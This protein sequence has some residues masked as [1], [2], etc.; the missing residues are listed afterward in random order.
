[1]V[2]FDKS[3]KVAAA[4]AAV[5]ITTSHEGGRPDGAKPEGSPTVQRD[6]LADASFSCSAPD[7]RT[8]LQEALAKMAQRQSDQGSAITNQSGLSANIAAVT[9]IGVESLRKGA[10][11]GNAPD[12]G[13]N[14]TFDLGGVGV[15]DF[16]PAAG[17][18]W[19][20]L[21]LPTWGAR[22]SAPTPP[23]KPTTQLGGG[24]AQDVGPADEP[25]SERLL[26]K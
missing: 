26:I 5:A 8:R 10:R 18:S 15:Q 12:S 19:D 9:Q 11:A 17:S 4:L 1:M 21:P 22:G 23:S 6:Q 14:P 7:I 25:S 20:Q 13:S 24:G 16:G 2:A 3:A